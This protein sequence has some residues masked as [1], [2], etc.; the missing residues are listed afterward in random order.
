MYQIVTYLSFPSTQG[1]DLSGSILIIQEYKAC[2]P[3]TYVFWNQKQFQNI[4]HATPIL[5]NIWIQMKLKSLNIKVYVVLPYCHTPLP[6]CLKQTKTSLIQYIDS[7]AIETLSQ[8]QMLHWLIQNLYL[9]VINIPCFMH[10][11]LQEKSSKLWE[12]KVHP[13]DQTF[14]R[15]LIKLIHIST[16]SRDMGEYK[17]QDNG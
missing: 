6:N 8:L 13:Q 11:V 10:Y 9:S 4:T 3:W 12:L 7:Q 1:P 15:L 14:L 5:Y 16:V 2:D 17:R